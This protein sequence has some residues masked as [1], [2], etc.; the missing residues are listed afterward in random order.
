MR[1]LLVVVDQSGVQQTRETRARRQRTASKASQ[2]GRFYSLAVG[3]G[4]ANRALRAAL[5]VTDLNAARLST[6]P[7][8]DVRR[9]KR[10]M[11]EPL[12]SCAGW[13]GLGPYVLVAADLKGEMSLP[14]AP[15]DEPSSSP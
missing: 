8:L 1:C 13:P 5:E 10:E 3:I 2:P 11:R 4:D 12:V 14:V 7:A 9:G 6:R 15:W